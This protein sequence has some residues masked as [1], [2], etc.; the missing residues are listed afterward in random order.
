MKL[1]IMPYVGVGPLRFGHGP[2]ETRLLLGEPRATR[3][4]PAKLREMH[5]G[6]IACIYE[7]ERDRLGLVEI[8]FTK[9]VRDLEY[10]GVRLF[11]IPRMEAVRRLVGDDPDVAEA[12]GSLVFLCLGL[13]MTGFH[14]GREESLAMT[15]FTRGRWDIHISKMKPFR[16]LLP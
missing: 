14:D 6:G 10:I 7:G 11:E 15:A 13:T 5:N 3:A 2:D 12:L 4:Q 16:L 8:G 9:T 1:D